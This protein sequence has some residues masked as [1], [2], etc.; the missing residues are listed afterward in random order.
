M[1]TRV[2]LF[3]AILFTAGV[4]FAF[5]VHWIAR[6][7]KPQFR[8]STEEPLADAAWI[9]AG[10]ASSQMQG[11]AVDVAPFRR[12]FDAIPRPMPP[13]PIYDFIK[14]TMDLRV[15]VT[16]AFGTVLFDSAGLD[17]GEDYSRW[18][19]VHLTLQGRY[20]TRTTTDLR[21]AQH[22]SIMYVA[23]PINHKGAIVGVVS[24]GKPSRA[25]NTFIDKARDKM[26]EG[27]M[28]TFAA[29]VIVTLITSAMI[30]RPIERLIAYT[31]AVGRGERIAA[32]RLGHGELGQL[33][34][35]FEEMRTALE[36]KR[37]IEQY[38][39]TLTHEMKS[40]LAAIQGA[41]EL[42]REPMPAEQHARFCENIDSESKRMHRLI[43]R[44]LLLAS[45]EQTSALHR[46]EPMELT[47]LVRRAL[48]ALTGLAQTKAVDMSL[49]GTAPVTVRGDALLMETAVV[50]LLQNALDFAPRGSSVEVAVHAGA[51]GA[52]LTVA[53]RGPGIP[54]YA[55]ER[56]FERFYSLKRPDTGKKS[57]GLGLSLVSEIMALHGGGVRLENRDDGGGVLAT[58]TFPA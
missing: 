49:V 53:D 31:R 19:D 55:I 56:V 51:D 12:M 58:L 4:G 25:V 15:Y 26:V 1:S 46:S 5:L 24:V 7:L 3:L 22:S 23:A 11:R 10:L 54:A 2:R 41:V 39:Q 28:I 44:L 47:D 33:G 36:G 37:T 38:I 14:T 40:P 34:R 35:A 42:L 29:V 27:G 16:D 50:N 9:L 18:N 52:T 6:D 20:G 21:L 13:A 17:E 48:A 57:T 32:P 43:E 45:I 8:V 30:T